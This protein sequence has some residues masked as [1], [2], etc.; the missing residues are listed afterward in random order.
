[1]SKYLKALFA[2]AFTA[3]GSTQTA[4][5]AGGGHIGF[6]AGI[7]IGLATLSSLAVVFGVPNAKS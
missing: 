6:V 1:M 7:T 5:V 4:Y 3:L 2:G